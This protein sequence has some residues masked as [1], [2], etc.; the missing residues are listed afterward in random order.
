MNEF[1]KNISLTNLSKLKNIYILKR[2]SYGFIKNLLKYISWL[3]DN[4]L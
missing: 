2:T 4:H 1:L 3:S